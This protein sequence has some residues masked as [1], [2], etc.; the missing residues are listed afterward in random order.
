MIVRYRPGD[1]LRQYVSRYVL[2][3]VTTPGQYAGGELNSTVKDHALVKATFALAFPDTYALG[4]SSLGMQVLYNV[5]N[6]HPDI[7]CERVYCPWTD[8]E[9]RL[10][11]CGAPLY[12]LETFTPLGRFDVVGVSM[13]YELNATNLLTMLDLAGIPLR[14]EARGDANPIVV[15]GGHAAFS[16][17]PLADFADAFAIGDGEEL[18]V[19]IALTVGRLRRAGT[20]REELL[21][22]LARTV[23]GVY[24]PRF[25]RFEFAAGGRVSAIAPLRPGLPLPVRRRAVSDFEDAPAPTRPVVPFVETIHDRYAVE[26]M[27]G[28]PNGCRFC[29]ASAIA[30][31]RRQRSPE[32]VMQIVREALANTGYD[33]VSLLSLSSSDYPDVVELARRMYEEFGAQG[34]GVSLP[35]LRLGTTLALLPLETSRVRKSGLTMAPEAATERLRKL[36]NKPVLDEDLFA[37]CAAAFRAGYSAVKLYFM[38]G[39]PGETDED[40]RAIGGLC[41]RV[42]ALRREASGKGPARVNA[43]ISSFV[44]KAWTPFE[45]EPMCSPSELLRRQALARSSLT[46]RNVRMRFHET[47]VSFI[48]GALARADRR[49][50]RAILEAWSRGARFDGWERRLNLALWEDAFRTA[51][52]DAEACAQRARGPGEILPWSIVSSH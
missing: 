1:D 20:P 27:R 35:S 51:R 26:I 7:A 5:L 17:E 43:S 14:A 47:G 50:G 10:R 19:E 48:E 38:I 31:P 49:M 39:L 25:Y 23:P 42:A 32:R 52:I 30:R 34:V 12:S 15:I 13:G 8:A 18:A 11:A 2:P 44:P 45:R 29:Q 24:V 22:E 16:P 41:E 4:M 37:G 28:C 6:S 40:V 21:Y 3:F 46:T 9:A 33:E 36:I